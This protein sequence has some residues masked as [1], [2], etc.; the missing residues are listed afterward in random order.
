MADKKKMPPLMSPSA[1]NAFGNQFAS[2]L[3]SGHKNAD[4]LTAKANEDAYQ[5]GKKIQGKYFKGQKQI[6]TEKKPKKE[7]VSTLADEIRAFLSEE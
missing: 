5:F 4:K 7:S 3:T 1:I 2:A 6:G